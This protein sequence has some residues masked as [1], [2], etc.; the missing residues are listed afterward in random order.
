MERKDF[1]ESLLKAQDEWKA[2]KVKTER[3]LEKAL[4][5]YEIGAKIHMK[6]SS[7]NYRGKR[8]LN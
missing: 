2:E 3:Q 8:R 5:S 7:K 6:T 4:D 1:T